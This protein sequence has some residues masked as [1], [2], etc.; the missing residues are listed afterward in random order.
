MP[1]LKSEWTALLVFLAL[2]FLFSEV[3]SKLTPFALSD[4][5]VTLAFSLVFTFAVGLEVVR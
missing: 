5:L 4:R 2:G 1:Y 3:A